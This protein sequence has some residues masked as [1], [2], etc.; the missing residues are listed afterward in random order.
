MR[1]AAPDVD[2]AFVKTARR[3]PFFD[4]V[5]LK[6][7]KL[8]RNFGAAITEDGDLIQWGKGYSATDFQ[9]TTTLKG[10]KLVD[11]AIS[12]DKIIALSSGGTVYS[13]PVAKVDQEGGPKLSEDSWIPFW[14]G[15]SDIS[16]RRL[17]PQ[18]LGYTEKVTQI[19]GG[20]EH[21]LLLTN[22]GR[23]F[24]AA[25]GTEHFPS[26]GQM[27]VPGL[28]WTTRP[29][30][31]YDICHEISTLKGFDIATVAAGDYHSFA[32]DRD[33]RVFAFGDNSLGQLGF[34]YSSESP[35]IDAPSLL[36]IQKLYAKT[37][38]APKVTSV[39]AG[40]VNSFFTI[41][42]T[43]VAG[44]GENP[45]EMRGLGRVT[46]DT[47]SCDQ[48]LFGGLGNGRWTHVQGVPTKLQALSGLFE[49]DETKNTVVPIR[50]SRISVGSTHASAV[51]NNVTYLGASDKSSEHDTNW[52]ADVLWWGGN[53]YY[54]L[55]TGRRNNVSN[56]I[57]IPPLDMAAEKDFGRREEH[58][59]QI[60]PRHKVNVNGRN[61]SMEQRIECG[62]FVT[63]V[64]S[65]V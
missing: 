13:I 39:H 44:Q 53:E 45:S 6:D 24:S 41:D 16:Y 57:Y 38:Q 48:G 10:R 18:S 65:G 3:I 35:A 26:K 33:G 52:G 23:V 15:R 30:G 50:L 4:G 31:P 27:G 63:A 46:A 36:P 56:P 11:I 20:L 55:G 32:L 43:R 17:Q 29:E 40:G 21:V 9:P 34:E 14:K 7:V 60:T 58:R 1:G 51:M 37:N 5:L 59:F 54:Q 49:Y 2:D 42:A 28:T 61:V 22:S 47:W 19:S 64:Y 25:S 62:R 8:D 12:R